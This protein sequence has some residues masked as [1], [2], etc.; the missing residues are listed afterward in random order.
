MNIESRNKPA[1]PGTPRG[2]TYPSQ[3]NE[4]YARGIL[5]CSGVIH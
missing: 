5:A 1:T 4:Y 3:K 2:L